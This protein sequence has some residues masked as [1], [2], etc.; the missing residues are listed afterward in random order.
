VARREG[1]VDVRAGSA[2]LPSSLSPSRAKDFEQCGLKFF[3]AAVLRWRTPPT[4]HTAVGNVGH[5]ALERLYLL[6]PEKRDTEAAAELLSDAWQRVLV[7]DDAYVDLLSDPA[8]AT[9]TRARAEVAVGNIFALEDPRRIVVDAG[10]LECWTAADLFG[11]P[12]RGRIDR[13]TDT[14]VWRVADYKT[15]KVPAPRYVEGALAGLFT[16]AASLAASHPDR[17]IPDEVELLYLAEPRRISRPVV[18]TYLLDHARKLGATWA[19]IVAAHDAAV[20]LARTG[21]LCG[22]CAFAPVCPM[23]T[24]GAPVPGSAQSDEQLLAMGLTRGRGTA[25]V[26]DTARD[27]DQ[28]A[29]ELAASGTEELS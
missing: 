16:Y 11:A 27:D 13:M 26:E 19:T 7:G 28:D 20:W 29:A 21:P 5:D 22:W 18:R 9:D 24:K 15:G 3:F 6:P 17:R 25:S 1:I 14:G 8:L 10:E 23:V 12:I 4:E 2:A